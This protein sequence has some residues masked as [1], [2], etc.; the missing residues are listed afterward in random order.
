MAEFAR[1]LLTIRADRA[2][3]G[4][5]FLIERRVAARFASKNLGISRYG[6]RD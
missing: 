4:R 2:V 5:I 6:L 1:Y 3:V